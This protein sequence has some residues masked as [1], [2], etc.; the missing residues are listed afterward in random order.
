MASWFPNVVH[1][2]LSLTLSASSS[3]SQP[4]SPPTLPLSLCHSLLCIPVSLSPS[5]SLPLFLPVS[6]C[7]TLLSLSLTPSPLL[8]HSLPHLSP[9][10]LSPYPL[11]PSPLSHLLPAYIR[12]TVPGGRSVL[13]VSYSAHTNMTYLLVWSHVTWTYNQKLLNRS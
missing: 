4:V 2:S 9:S 1:L 6:V 5:P 13:T 7:H 11:S 3:L 10:P 12:A 8:S